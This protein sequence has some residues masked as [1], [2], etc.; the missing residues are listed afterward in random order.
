MENQ[1]AYDERSRWLK[2]TP[3]AKKWIS[4]EPGLDN[5][6]FGLA[7]DDAECPGTFGKCMMENSW[8]LIVA[9]AETGPGARPAELDYFRSARDQCAKAGVPFFLKQVDN[10]RLPESRL[11]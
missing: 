5:V 6:D 2:E 9:G 8:D 7:Y 10:K 3:A 1:R 4:F 11:P